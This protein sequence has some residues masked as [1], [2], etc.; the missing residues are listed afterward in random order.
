MSVIC[1]FVVREATEYFIYE[2]KVSQTLDHKVN[3]QIKDG[4][5]ECPYCFA[6]E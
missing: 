5:P 3:M 6:M 4:Q 1:L 2:A